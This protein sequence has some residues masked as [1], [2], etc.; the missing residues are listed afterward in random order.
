MFS[1]KQS[2]SKLWK[3][4]TK[5][6]N[7]IREGAR[8]DVGNGK[9]I[10]FWDHKWALPVPLSSMAMQEIPPHLDDMTVDE[11]WDTNL[12]WKWEIFSYVLPGDVLRAIDAHHVTPSEEFEDQL[13]WDGTP[14]SK[15]SIKSSIK[16]I[17]G[18]TSRAIGNKRWEVVW[19]TL[20]PQRVRMFLWLALHN[21]DLTN[22]NRVVRHLI[23]DPRCKECGAQEE[24]IDHILRRC[25]HAREFWHY[26]G[27]LGD[28]KFMTTPFNP[29][30]TD[31]LNP[32]NPDRNDRW[33]T[34]FAMAIWWLWK[35]R[36]C[37]TFDRETDIRFNKVAFVRDRITEVENAPSR[38]NSLHPND[39]PHRLEALIT[40]VPPSDQWALLNTNGAAK[41]NPGPTGGGGIIRGSQGELVEAFMEKYGVCTSTWAELKAVY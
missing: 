3:D 31:N 32:A 24:D 39:R 19:I 8:L 40:W 27:L 17:R 18:E 10:F 15:F 2:D 13:Y 36:C 6:K 21:Y 22:I 11:A 41:G 38:G 30:L 26:L 14:S 1:A 28:T 33:P 12:G 5:N 7:V 37:R 29:W 25:T 35:W 16:I 34:A 4:I 9:R 23:D 20:I